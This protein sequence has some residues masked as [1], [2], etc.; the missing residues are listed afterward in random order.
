M[1][2]WNKPVLCV[3]VAL[4][5]G[6]YSS[7]GYSGTTGNGASQRNAGSAQ[8]AAPSNGQDT[9]AA[10]PG[11]AGAAAGNSA[12]TVTAEPVA[13]APED[14]APQRSVIS[15]DGHPIAFV[16]TRGSRFVVVVDGK[17]TPKYD[18]IGHI[19]N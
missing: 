18:E 6:A 11:G 12:L 13:S 19:H 4:G 17:P 1:R 7:N 5:V 10:S 2:Y 16:S 8:P 14:Q 9:A 15:P 3:A